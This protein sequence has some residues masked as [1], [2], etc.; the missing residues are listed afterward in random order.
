MRENELTEAIRREILSGTVYVPE[1][2][3]AI[4]EFGLVFDR[5][6]REPQRDGGEAA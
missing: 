1:R 5:I 6:P 2:D 3:Q 4:R